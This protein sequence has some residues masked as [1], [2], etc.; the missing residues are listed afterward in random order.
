M[1]TTIDQRVVEMRFD[2][3][4]F[5]A[6]VQTSMSTLDKLKQKLN[7]T[8]A[9]KGLES[10]NTAAKNVNMSGLG[11]A[12]ESVS[13]K[14]SALQ[15]AGVTALAN[16]T[17][18][19]VNT[20]K[21]MVKALTIDPITTGFQE[22]ETKINAIQTIMSNTASK[23][24]TME[25]VT[26]VL[27][28]LNTY[29]DKTI[30][31]FAEMTRNI[32]T[33]TA[34]GVGLEESASAIQGIA[35]LAA[36]SGSNSQQASTAMYQLS[37]ALAAGTV[38]LMDWN[39]VVNA[40]M[41]GE[42]FQEA[43]KATARDHG[44][45]VD[46]M[47]E[48]NGSFRESLHEGWI[49]ADIL[50][51]TLRKFTVE[52]ATEYA[53][54]MMESGKWTKEQADAL[55]A[56][57]QSME[58]A[59]TKVKTF[60]QLWDTM[61]ESVQSGWAQTWEI[62]IGDFEEAK[63]LLSGISEFFGGVIGKSADN[64]NTIL[65]NALN[66]NPFS[67]LAER[68]ESVTGATEAMT[69]ATKNYSAIADKVINGDFGNGEARIKAL[70]EAG[71]DW[72]Y[73]QNLVNEKLGDSTRHATDFKESQ[74]GL[75]EAQKT[76]IEDLVKMSDAQ[77]ENLGFT[78]DEIEAFRELEEQSKKTGIPINDLIKDLDQLNGRTLLINSFK[79]AGS[80]L[81]AVLTSI[82]T[83]WREAFWGDA[84]EE[85]ILEKKSER[86]YNIIAAIHKF[87]T[88]LAADKVPVEEL[89]R[90]FKG[91][92]AV[93]D[94]V[95][96]LLG[97]GF[98]LAFEV[99]STVLGAFDMNV[100][101]LTANIGD[102]LVAFRDWLF[103]GNVLAKSFEWLASK[104]PIAVNAIKEWF[105]AFKEIPAVQKFIDAIEDF[106]STL[107]A[108]FDP[109]SF[110]NPEDFVH[111]LGVALGNALKAIPEIMVE[112]GKDIWEGFQNGLESGFNGS[113][114]GKIVS[115]GLEFIAGFAEA[116]G[117]QSPSWKAYDIATDFLQGAI[118]GIKDAAGNVWEALKT[119]GDQIVK[120][121]KSLWDFITDDNGNIEWGK[122][123]SIGS[124]L[125]MIW[126][127]KQVADAING[128]TDVIGG[129]ANLTESLS[130]G[131]KR[132][133]KAVSADF[134]AKAVQ[135]MAISLAILV[136]SIWVLT[137]IDD[138]GKLWSAVGVIV[139]LSGVLV[140]LALAMD[141][142][143]QASVKIGKGGV[144]IEGLK[145]SIMQIGIA[146]LLLA[147]V[148]K[149][150]GSMNPEEAEQGFIGLA[151]MAVGMIAFMAA[152]GGISRYAGNM[153]Q[154]G[155]TMRKMATAMLL[156]TIV[157]KLISGMDPSD[158]VVGIAVMEVF[159]LFFSQMA[160]ASGIA[161][162]SGAKFGGTLLKASVAMML[163]AGVIK[164]ISGM[165][166]ADI[167][168]GV[169]AMEAFVLLFAQMAIANR[170]A[171]NNATAF[172]TTI[173]SMSVSMLL[174]SGVLKILSGMDAGD[175]I[176]GIAIMEVFV[177]LIAEMLLISKLGKDTGKVAGTILSM[178]VAIGILAGVSVLL[179]M[180]DLGGLIKGITAVGILGLIMSGMVKSLK[181]AQ[182]AK[183]AIMM[184]SI[185]IGVMAASVAAL[186][187]IDAGKLVGATAALSML[188]GMF[189]VM[190]KSL[191]KMKK[192]SF[193]S[194]VVMLGVITILAGIIT[195]LS[196][197][198]VG[199]TLEIAA[200]LSLL[201]ASLSAS[202]LLISKIGPSAMSAMPAAL[203]M[204][205]ILAIIAII[206]GVLATLNVGPTLEIAE[207]LSVLLLSLSTA[208]AIMAGAA[209]IAGVAAAG[210]T[211]L[212]AL[213]TGMGVLM[214]AIAGLVTLIPD[215]E[216]FL[217]QALPILKLIGQGIGEFLG[218]IIAGIGN[219]ILDLLPAFGKALS[220]FMIGA[221]PF[222]TMAG[223]INGNVIE[224]V[225]YLAGAI[226]ALT[227]AN[228]ISGIGQ[229]LSFGQSFADLGSQLSAFIINA[230]PFLTMMT[231][232]DPAAIES[233]K[234]LASMILVLTA[235]DL[236]DG[237]MSF[238]GGGVDFASFGTQ[239]TAFGESMVEF[240]KTVSGNIDPAAVEAAA[241]A[242]TMMAELQKSLPRTG[243]WIQEIAGEQDLE[244]FGSACEEFG[245][246][247]SKFSKSV[248]GD[249]AV[250]PAA[251]EAAAKAGE[252][253]S[254]LQSSLPRTGGWIQ[255]VAGVQDLEA[256]G[257]SCE[258]FGKS[259]SRFSKSVSGDNAVDPAAV[260][261]ASKAGELM[262]ALQETL[263]KTG[264]WLQEI[265][266]VQDLQDFGSKIEAFGTA[267]TNFSTN[268]T[269][270]ETAVASAANAGSMM[271]EL[272][273]AIPTDKWFDGK[274]QLDD[275]GSKIQ[276]FGS[277][278][279]N[280]SNT[281]SGIDTVKMAGSI[282]QAKNLVELTKSVVELDTSG[283]SSF[284]S[285]K[286]IATTMKGYSEEVNGINNEAVDGSITAANRLKYFVNSL[287]D[288]DTSGISKFKV[289]SIG[290][291]MKSYINSVSGMDAG[292]VSS[293]IT[294]ANRLKNFIGSLVDLDSSGINNFKVGTIGST[295]KS[296][297]GSVAGIDSGSIDSSITAATRL[298]NFI[299]SLT[300]LNTGGVSSFVDAIEELGTVSI[301][302]I[303]ESFS[304]ASTKMLT[305]G[306]NLI[307]SVTKG[308]QS[309]QTALTGTVTKLVTS[310]HKYITSKASVF[311][312]AG[313]Q[314]MIRFI[315]GIKSK[316]GAVSTVVKTA[317]SSAVSGARSHYN[318]FYNAGTYLGSGLVRG[319]NSKKTSAYNAGYALGRAAVQGE[320][321]GQKSNSP[322][323][324]TIQA[325][326]WIGEGLVIGMKKMGSKVYDTGR[327]L[328][329]TTTKSISSAITKVS[330]LIDSG[331]DTTPTIRPVL[332]LSDIQI[333][334]DSINDML[335]QTM[336]ISGY[337]NVSAIGRM[338][339]QR[340]QNGESGEVVSA[341]NKLRKDLGN[342]QGN[343]YNVNGVT[344]DDGSAISEA[345]QALVRA[346]RVERRM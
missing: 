206:L 269:V 218:G 38:K 298:K 265:A 291:T 231:I 281:I 157:I 193:S 335:G 172:G 41:G 279:V 268:T 195:A 289:D 113:I 280:Y 67:K 64:R 1:S 178:S 259:I 91:L 257:A 283:I 119:V 2:N 101:D 339:N 128:V 169:L 138:V 284:K 254:A 170:I 211:P 8:G 252:L 141:K 143:S 244:A 93:L 26:R 70:T 207:S 17:N 217:S 232:I 49:S 139:V 274:V 36:A 276:S 31:N 53:Q 194:L 133:S 124:L 327:N 290:T 267:L 175:V 58:D 34:A 221:Q 313:S 116:L 61:K 162:D 176:K 320:K 236:L 23:G 258:E 242:G 179:S 184:M 325:G 196:L 225:G 90:T 146:L 266:G 52:G 137:T 115:F 107:S 85:E 202:I 158:I 120:V 342:I 28:E 248:S 288:L 197:L 155:K 140:A 152:L 3:K 191:G 273:N 337:A 136:A 173:L 306:S 180:V 323:K 270:D 204:S 37:Q 6:N 16:I 103:E 104:I 319:I 77:L 201:L 341:I 314:I 72:A 151:G 271:A 98:K 92:F 292:V 235:A 261:A 251:V 182:N 333:G 30:Y 73:I 220:D 181:G 213:I 185:A 19:A 189:A 340:N 110:G 275:F 47:I 230:T 154:F 69:E 129:F 228:L 299:A 338:M 208:C 209:A 164:I 226:L 118:N 83:A 25:D 224:G 15:I 262:S 33:F 13:A 187:F 130:D 336:S 188:M 82:K 238:F 174:L 66:G 159:V 272:Q 300:D 233:A 345:V 163:M 165:D 309:K 127:L 142:M 310:A 100:L 122:I 94:I 316:T 147:V 27:D 250:D 4:Q 293:S 260:E 126:A 282:Y 200:S 332:D 102:A 42:K 216:S 20:G 112:I 214:A 285:V 287:V 166:P 108:L 68:I 54:S 105:N 183:G 346:A 80:G 29:A 32:G 123:F 245:K 264:G 88:N 65:E 286:D 256:F 35:N 315:A 199:S 190:S 321:D 86:L 296:Y 148:V 223:T 121:F 210:L 246:S 305:A 307:E 304:G 239:L 149:L 18:S 205:G 303:V 109:K 48:K 9:S 263:P 150:V 302:G 343:T 55:I 198:N 160:V 215:L 75:N 7:L 106:K 11:S 56:E 247:I 344:Y 328:G 51:E 301:D 219:A 96:T 326:K 144:N 243:G 240:S 171:G 177:L 168:V 253:M 87:S 192:G 71:Y 78:K 59:A 312:T 40:G 277:S 308:I 50:N 317:M 97:G 161:G 229:F 278:L 44:I 167:L 24:T 331:M 10:I 131:V 81:V 297:S 237:I 76:T 43:L 95:T 241:A 5:E 324:L 125:G 334:A 117:V 227:A 249:N 39:S 318:K 153:E 135:K 255:E 114:I 21:R 212:L 46:E 63:E 60:T 111:D 222:I 329:E 12:V 74:E 156:M 186:S 134:K 145:S 234:N 62:I 84:T 14:F 203:V 330:D 322:S 295:L 99:L 45:A 22:Y 89:T 132:I 79:N 311:G 294:S 57:A